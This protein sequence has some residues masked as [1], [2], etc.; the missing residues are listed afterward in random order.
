MR[1]FN[2]AS[3]EAAGDA[4]EKAASE[5]AAAPPSRVRVLLLSLLLV[6]VIALGARQFGGRYLGREI[7]IPWPFSG[8][9]DTPPVND[10]R[11]TSPASSAPATGLSPERP[12]EVSGPHEVPRSGLDLGA[13]PDQPVKNA[14]SQ[15]R[16]SSAAPSREPRISKA[17]DAASRGRFSLQVGAMARE[18]NAHA[19]RLRLEQ[20]GYS[21][22]I[23]KG[24]ASISQHVVSVPVPGDRSDAQALMEKLGA[25]G[26][27]AVVIESG[28]RYRV[29]AG[30]SVLL[31]EAIDIARDVQKKGFTPTIAA[32]TVSTT[33][34]LVRVGGFSSRGKASQK[35]QEL[36]KKGFS[37]LI[38]KDTVDGE[39]TES[40]RHISGS[41]GGER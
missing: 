1:R 36:R 7:Y 17:A 26:F 31:D 5:R 38:A 33:L 15:S 39:A 6:V 2:L 16:R 27:S 21:S 4:D 8:R 37:V 22:S 35:A 10:A 28:G 18:A 14:D 32:E 13:P 11:R 20:L 9:I 23:R 41:R 34:Y 3:P 25:A 40:G 29:E 24:R 19:L 12:A 30:R